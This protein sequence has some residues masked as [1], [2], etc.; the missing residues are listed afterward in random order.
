MQKNF[1]VLSYNLPLLWELWTHT[2]GGPR[3]HSAFHW[4][5]QDYVP[6]L[7]ISEIIPVPSLVGNCSCP[8]IPVGPFHLF[9]DLVMVQICLVRSVFQLK[10]EQ[11]QEQGLFSGL[12][13]W[14]KEVSKLVVQRFSNIK[15]IDPTT[16]VCAGQA[17]HCTLA[18]F[19]VDA[20]DLS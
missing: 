5:I 3:G 1:R 2:M 4:D 15:G 7:G 10:Q 6:I 9:K 18:G 13:T 8:W 11:E 12:S 14:V 20:T 17:Q 16:I 19:L